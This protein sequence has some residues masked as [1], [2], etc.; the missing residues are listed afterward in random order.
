MESDNT[1]WI[2]MNSKQRRTMKRR[3]KYQVTVGNVDF[4]TRMGILEWIG[5]CH[6]Q[7]SGEVR[8]LDNNLLGF[9]A[10]R[11]AIMF[12]LKFTTNY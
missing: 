7:R 11:D 9:E 3:F 5:H 6:S 8:I 1:A 12:K 4:D 2:Y 10:E